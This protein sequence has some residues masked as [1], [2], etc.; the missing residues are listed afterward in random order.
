MFDVFCNLLKLHAVSERSLILM[1]FFW[2]MFKDG[3]KNRQFKWMNIAERD[4]STASKA[5][6]FDDEQTSNGGNDETSKVEDQTENWC[7]NTT[8]TPLLTYLRMIIWTAW[9]N[10]TFFIVFFEVKLTCLW[11]L[12]FRIRKYLFDL[13]RLS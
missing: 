1:M 13:S 4:F 11:Y 10:P 8:S 9:Q 7:K 6:D 2:W 12:L 5:P 3:Y